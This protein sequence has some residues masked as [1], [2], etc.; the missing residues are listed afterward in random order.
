MVGRILF[1][2]LLATA[3]VAHAEPPPDLT[4]V[5][6]T[7]GAF[8]PEQQKRL[9]DA[10]IIDNSANTYQHKRPSDEETFA[11]AQICKLAYSMPQITELAGALGWKAREEVSRMGITAR[12]LVKPALIDR[13]VGNLD[14]DRRLEIGDRLACPNGYTMERSWDGSVI[15][16]IRRT[17]TKTM[18]GPSVAYIG[19][20]VYAI[21][22]QEGHMRRINGANPSCP[23]PNAPD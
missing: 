22:A 7:W 19:L 23:P 18:D 1:L 10:F 5:K 8:T 17:G 15:S 9:R 13:A 21:L 16:A 11:A 14:D 4:P 3:G 20:G 12:G 6:C 2:L